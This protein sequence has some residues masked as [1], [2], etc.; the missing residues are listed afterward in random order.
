MNSI[1]VATAPAERGVRR[2]QASVRRRVMKIFEKIIFI[3]VITMPAISY[4][5]TD[6]VT[7]GSF[8]QQLS[9]WAA[10]EFT[11]G[12][13]VT[14]VTEAAN[15]YVKLHHD[16]VQ[17]WCSIHQEMAS[18]LTKGVMYRFSYKYKTSGTDKKYLGIRFSDTSS[19]MHSTAINEDYGWQHLLVADD[20][21]HTDSF[22]FLVGDTLPKADEPH[23]D[24]CLDYGTVGDIY[25]D[26]VSILPD[27][28]Q[29]TCSNEVVKFTSGTPAKASEVNANFDAMNCQIQALKAIVCQDHPTADICK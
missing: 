22:T 5:T 8:A 23:L 17:D 4:S 13:H 11:G 21:W 28:G 9:G 16:T 25:I 26:D 10:V 15:V 18:K 24:I 7:N 2:T 27:S 29:G 6:L 3:I 1:F 20:K 14:V 12:S 19:V